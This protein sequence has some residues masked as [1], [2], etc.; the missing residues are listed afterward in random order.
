MLSV[1]HHHKLRTPGFQ[2]D[3]GYV[4]LE[5]RSRKSFS[6]DTFPN[7][8]PTGSPFLTSS[9]CVACPSDSHCQGRSCAP[10]DGRELPRPGH[11]KRTHWQPRE[12]RRHGR[13]HGRSVSRFWSLPGE[14]SVTGA[15]LFAEM[16]FRVCPRE[17]GVMVF[18]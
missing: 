7:S 9:P 5:I 2:V 14:S 17:G 16:P 11:W 18:H 4:L 1:V 13:T 15:R 6:N 8:H 10:R 3:C 12:L